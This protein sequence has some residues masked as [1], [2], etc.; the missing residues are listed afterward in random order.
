MADASMDG[1]ASNLDDAPE[2]NWWNNGEP[3]LG[4]AQQIAD[5]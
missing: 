5:R 4:E 1:G 3:V 2:D